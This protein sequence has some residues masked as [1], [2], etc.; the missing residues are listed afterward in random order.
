MKILR[1]PILSDF[2]NKHI[3]S[4][5]RATVLSSVSLVER[6]VVT[7]LYPIIGFLADVSLNYALMFLGVLALIFTFITR[8]EEGYLS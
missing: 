1:A 8:I 2:M 3:D 5:N 7:I 6:I 4:K